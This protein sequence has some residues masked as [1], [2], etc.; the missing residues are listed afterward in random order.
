MVMK[1]Q[2]AVNDHHLK[3]FYI[4]QG[5]FPQKIM[6][7]RPGVFPVYFVFHPRDLRGGENEV[8]L[9]ENDRRF[10][11]IPEVVDQHAG[12]CTLARTAD[13][14]YTDDHIR[15]SWWSFSFWW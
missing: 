4:E 9:V 5:G 14:S 1:S 10:S 7:D 13:A 12:Q 11:R 2:E 8:V 15:T 3:P 6:I